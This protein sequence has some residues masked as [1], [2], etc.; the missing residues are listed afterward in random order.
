MAD[1]DTTPPQRPSR[2]RPGTGYSVGRP[3]Q[4]RE[5]LI[6]HPGVG[7]V[8]DFS[9]TT[10]PPTQLGKRGL[11]EAVPD[12][13]DRED[14]TGRIDLG[15]RRAVAT[16]PP[17]VARLTQADLLRIVLGVVGSLVVAAVV[18]L[19][20]RGCRVVDDINDRPTRNEVREDIRRA[21]EPLDKKLDRL[22]ERRP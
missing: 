18:A 21:T 17:P 11:R 3:P 14:I 8:E 20:T 2:T 6:T 10:P 7:A 5:R 19:V 13:I 16:M 9:V 1:D 15:V 12:P 22:L 4:G